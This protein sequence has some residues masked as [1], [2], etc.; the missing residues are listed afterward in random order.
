MDLVLRCVEYEVLQR[1]PNTGLQYSYRIPDHC[2]TRGQP[3]INGLSG[4]QQQRMILYADDIALLCGGID[5]PAEILNIYDKT[6]TR[7]GLKISTGKTTM[8]FNVPEEIKAKL[9]LISIAG[10]ALKNVR[11]FKYLGHM[12]TNNDDDPSHYLSF[13]ISSAFQ[14]WN[15][16]KHI[17][18]DKKMIM[19]TCIKRLEAC[20]RSRFLYSA[21]SW[22]L[23]ASELRKLET[24]WHGFLRKIITNDF[25][26]KNI[27]QEYL[28]AKKEAKNSNTTIPEPD[29]LDW[30]YIFNNEKL[31]T[32]T[33]T[34]NIS[35]FCKIQHLKCIA[36]VIRLANNSLQI[37]LLFKT[38]HNKYSLDPWLKREKELN[39][40]KIQIQK[41]MQNKNRVHVFTLPY[42]Y[43]RTL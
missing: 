18:T 5:E 34:S 43:I 39:I 19:S 26:R 36:H 10:V 20:V 16:L 30:A 35:S 8:A 27:S 12:V 38:N 4:N 15:E 2:S 31:R 28:K 33:K 23:S 6:F 42:F 11:T 14:K 7:F 1:F 40:S 3:S 25:K 22:E 13:R 32:I 17:L 41:I 37:Q 9:S 21:Q 24:I 29:G